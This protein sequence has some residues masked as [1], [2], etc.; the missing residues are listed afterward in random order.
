SDNLPLVALIQ[1]PD[2]IVDP[3]ENDLNKTL[4]H[5]GPGFIASK[6]PK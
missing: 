3:K 6:P 2:P 5:Y 4:S 1:H